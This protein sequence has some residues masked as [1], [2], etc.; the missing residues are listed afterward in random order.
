MVCIWG[1]IM[2]KIELNLVFILWI[3]ELILGS[4]FSFSF[5]CMYWSNVWSF[6]FFLGMSVVG[7]LNLFVVWFVKLK[8]RFFLF[9]LRISW[10]MVWFCRLSFVIFFKRGLFLI[11]NSFIFWYMLLMLFFK[12]RMFLCELLCVDLSL[13]KLSCLSSFL[14]IFS[15][16]LVI[17]FC[18]WVFN[19][20]LVIDVVVF[21]LKLI[22]KG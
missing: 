16:S 4:L 19:L 22:V 15:L 13:Y 7:M 3:C 2:W 6:C 5:F 14:W 9:V 8:I 20:V 12:S 11:L 17:V 10:L 21:V 1:C 18:R